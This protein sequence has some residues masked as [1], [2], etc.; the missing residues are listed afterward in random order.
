[1]LLAVESWLCMLWYACDFVRIPLTYIYTYPYGCYMYTV[2][3][4]Y[5]YIYIC[6]Y[7]YHYCNCVVWNINIEQTNTNNQFTKP[8]SEVDSQMDF[9]ETQSQ[10]IPTMFQTPLTRHLSPPSAARG[11]SMAKAA[12]AAAFNFLETTSSAAC[13]SA[14]RL[15]PLRWLTED[16]EK[17]WK[18]HLGH[19]ED[20]EKSWRFFIFLHLFG[21]FLMWFSHCSN[22]KVRM[23]WA[24]LSKSIKQMSASHHV[25]MQLSMNSHEPRPRSRQNI[26]K[27]ATRFVSAQSVVVLDPGSAKMLAWVQRNT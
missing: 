11:P 6:T 9:Q 16:V 4:I 19:R 15:G 1:M 3:C 27:H 25:I 5:I 10:H 13:L 7:M 17:E 24:I 26:M 20:V 18:R 2:Y 23:S 14:T 21:I 8:C 12:E 22:N